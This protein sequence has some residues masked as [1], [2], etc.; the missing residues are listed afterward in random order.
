MSECIKENFRD[1]TS[2]ILLSA[3]T[4]IMPNEN[5]MFWCGSVITKPEDPK[6]VSL[7]DDV[8][9]CSLYS[10]CR[11][12]AVITGSGYYQRPIQCPIIVPET[13]R[14]TERRNIRMIHWC[15]KMKRV[16]DNSGSLEAN[17]WIKN[18]CKFLLIV[19]RQYLNYWLYYLR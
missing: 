3:F 18:S 8:N 13:V 9:Y 6:K 10:W 17:H 14:S 5:N 2:I 15:L 16:F 12:L 11:P 1:S 19:L 4:D 7:N